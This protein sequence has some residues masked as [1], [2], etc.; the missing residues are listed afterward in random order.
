MASGTSK[1][2]LTSPVKIR[3]ALD[4]TREG[5]RARERAR[6]TEL[7]GRLPATGTYPGKDGVRAETG[8]ALG[9]ARHHRG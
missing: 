3:R 6:L 7:F 4:I 5:A 2:Q 1:G 8:R 9:K